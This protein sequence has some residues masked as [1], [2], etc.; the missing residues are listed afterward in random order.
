MHLVASQLFAAS[1]KLAGAVPGVCIGPPFGCADPGAGLFVDAASSTSLL[2]S[3]SSQRSTPTS[4]APPN[5]S[6][7]PPVS[8]P[9][10]VTTHT[11]TD[12]ALYCAPTPTSLG[13]LPTIGAVGF[14]SE[15]GAAPFSIGATEVHNSTN[16]LLFY[17]LSPAP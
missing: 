10:G 7:I 3:R 14:D 13:C 1:G 2:E 17:G 16:G 6:P 4:G 11:G 12:A 5:L 9:G 15:S 8:A